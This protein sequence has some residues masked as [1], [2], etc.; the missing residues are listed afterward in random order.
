MATIS[1]V[2]QRVFQP[3]PAPFYGRD[4]AAL[5]SFGRRINYLRI[6][7]T[8][9]CNFR[10]V[11][12]MP[13]HGAHF[14]P[15]EDLLRDDELLR[16]VGAAAAVGFEKIRL[17]GGEPTIRRNLVDLVRGI[18]ATPGIR[19]VSMTTNGLKLA[20]Q[21][22]ALREAGLKRV[23]IS[24][25]SLNPDKFRAMTRGGDFGRV[26]AGIEAAER[27]GFTPLKLNSVVVRGLNDDEVGDLARLTLD[28]PWQFRFI[29]MM[30]LA[31]VGQMAEESVVPTTEIIARL[32]RE[33]GAL[34]FVGWFGSDPARTYRLPGGKGTLGFI[35]SITEPFCSTCNRMRLTADGKL[36]LCLLRDNELDLQGALRSGASDEDIQ[37]LI[38]QAVFLKP[39][40]HGL[41]EGV[42]PT[43]RGMS[44]LGG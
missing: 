7:L 18:A 34:E 9:R 17:T 15:R 20:D 37:A 43:L 2:E 29:E 3:A 36:H 11:Y 16:V 39:W 19:E 32:E 12:C 38:R 1:L 25:D 44:E 23:N 4:D 24:I 42:K 40:G 5:D 33:F 6:S 26:W 14:A 35:S 22:E 27:A 41:P 13:E 30:P 31:G 8:D 21:A 10:C 28:R